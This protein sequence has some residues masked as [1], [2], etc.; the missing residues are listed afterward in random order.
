MGV[1]ER[2]V[3]G[4]CG[5]RVCILYTPRPVSCAELGGDCRPSGRLACSTRNTGPPPED[6]AEGENHSSFTTSCPDCTM[7]IAIT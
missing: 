6:C 7:H 4:I 5:V 1:S 3:E 2:G